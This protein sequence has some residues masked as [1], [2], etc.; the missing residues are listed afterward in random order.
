[1]REIFAADLRSAHAAHLVVVPAGGEGEEADEEAEPGQE[2]QRAA[3]LEHVAR[4][5]ND[6][7]NVM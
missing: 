7:W 1:M 3:D 4:P 5:A 2:L 6:K